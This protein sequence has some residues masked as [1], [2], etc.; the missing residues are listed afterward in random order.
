MFKS[1]SKLYQNNCIKTLTAVTFSL[2]PNSS[3]SE[4][5]VSTAWCC[6]FVTQ[7]GKKTAVHFT[8]SYWPLTYIMQS[9]LTS[10]G[11]LWH[12]PPPPYVST[13]CKT[14]VMAHVT[15]TTASVL[16][17]LMVADLSLGSAVHARL[18]DVPA[19]ICWIAT[20]SRPTTFLGLVIGPVEFPWPHWP[21][22][23]LPHAYTSLSRRWLSRRKVKQY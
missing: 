16:F 3:V 13:S 12:Q 22:E 19:E 10:P 5:Q 11:V 15:F 6:Y 7:R 9:L 4:L 2:N 18:C 17:T 8:C 1:L 14:Q 23:L 20:P 21:M